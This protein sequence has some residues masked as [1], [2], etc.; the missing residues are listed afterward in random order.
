MSYDVVMDEWA[1]CFVD[2]NDFIDLN[3]GGVTL[4][5]HTVHLKQ[6]QGDPPL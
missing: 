2:R 4:Y 3:V 6:K 1:L 5:S